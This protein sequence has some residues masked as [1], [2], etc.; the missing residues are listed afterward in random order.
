M[1]NN[2]KDSIQNELN[3][4]MH[5]IEEEKAKM[6]NYCSTMKQFFLTSSTNN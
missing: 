1:E 6:D 2:D 4:L 5:K 3:E